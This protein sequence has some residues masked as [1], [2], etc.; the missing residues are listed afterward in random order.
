MDP[1]DLAG[2]WYGYYTF[3]EGYS[4][5]SLDKKVFFIADIIVADNGFTGSISDDVSTGG[6]NDVATIKGKYTGS[7]LSFKKEYRKAHYGDGSGNIITNEGEAPIPVTYFGRHDAATNSIVGEWIILSS[8]RNV[9]NGEFA[10][11]AGA[12]EMRREIY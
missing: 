2:R 3:L 9:G 8:I 5:A 10:Q 4:P 12:W 11:C 6:V 7:K 1:V